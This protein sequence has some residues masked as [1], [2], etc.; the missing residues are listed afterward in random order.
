MLVLTRKAGDRIVIDGD[1]VLTV[2]HVGNKRVRFAIVAPDDVDI[3]R[4]E[5]TTQEDTNVKPRNS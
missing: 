3:E 5:Q 2:I 4:G 1:I